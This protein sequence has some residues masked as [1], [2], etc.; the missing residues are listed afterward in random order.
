MLS[1]LMKARTQDGFVPQT[2]TLNFY[3]ILIIFPVFSI[4]MLIRI[5]NKTVTLNKANGGEFDILNGQF[6]NKYKQQMATIYYREVYTTR[7][8]GC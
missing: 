3:S 1:Q 2:A 4:L 8:T 7:I 6:R 5:A